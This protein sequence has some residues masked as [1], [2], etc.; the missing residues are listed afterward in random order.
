[1]S[2]DRQSTSLLRTMAFVAAGAL[3]GCGPSKDDLARLL[4]ENEALRRELALQKDAV[5]TPAPME[6]VTAAPPSASCEPLEPPAEAVP[7]GQRVVTRAYAVTATTA[8]AC[9]PPDE[10]GNV[11]Y[12][13]ELLVEARSEALSV[14]S[15]EVQDDKSYTFGGVLP[16]GHACG[17]RLREVSSIEKGEKARGYFYF[18]V[19]AAATGKT[20]K[21]TMRLGTFKRQTIKVK[22]DR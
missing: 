10:K 17:P 12:G 8:A 16:F 6:I 18:V 22:L 14:P 20:L 13:V 3:C 15:G 7:L 11:L 5:I 1:M 2:M 4:Q 21:L 9:G 19:P